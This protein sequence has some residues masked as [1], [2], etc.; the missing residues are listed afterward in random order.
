MLERTLTSAGKIRLNR[1]LHFIS[2]CIFQAVV[3]TSLR[4]TEI[5]F[6]GRHRDPVLCCSSTALL[7]YGFW[8]SRNTAA[9]AASVGV[10][11]RVFVGK[12]T[13]HLRQV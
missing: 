7:E 10:C 13:P 4:R 6:P 12:Q 8:A 9:T 5:V 11:M 3:E 1:V 2:Y